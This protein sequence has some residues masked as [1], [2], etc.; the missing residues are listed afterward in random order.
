MPDKRF[1]AEQSKGPL[2]E[3]YHR[4]MMRWVRGVCGT[5]IAAY[6][7]VCRQMVDACVVDG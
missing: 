7:L 6:Q 3:D 4:K 1:V 2:T 5:Y